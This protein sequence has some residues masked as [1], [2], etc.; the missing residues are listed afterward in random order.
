VIAKLLRYASVSAIATA[1]SL[2]ILGVLVASGAAPP[3]WA[4]V[5]ATAAG[6]VPS[7]EL[8]RRWVW[9]KRGRRSCGREIGPFCALSFLG[10]AL[11]TIAV[12]AASNWA[13]AAGLGVGARTLV[14]EAANITTFGTL[15]VAQFVILDR[16]LFRTRRSQDVTEQPAGSVPPT[17]APGNESDPV[18][19]PQAA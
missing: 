7:F 18:V 16:V 11:S 3:G 5:I 17:E 1:V 12:N 10:L 6:T 15:W 14:A 2:I 19:L 4:N 8:N 13:T 9:G